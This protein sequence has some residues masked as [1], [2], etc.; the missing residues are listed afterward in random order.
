MGIIEV[1][2]HLRMPGSSGAA[3]VDIVFESA[4]A[5]AQGTKGPVLLRIEDMKE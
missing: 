2:S 3:G 1:A 5:I 4:W